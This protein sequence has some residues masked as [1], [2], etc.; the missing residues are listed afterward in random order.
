MKIKLHSY[1]IMVWKLK[2]TVEKREF[3]VSVHEFSEL[4]R[5]AY[6]GGGNDGWQWEQ[7]SDLQ[8]GVRAIH[9]G[10]E[11][12]NLQVLQLHPDLHCSHWTPHRSSLPNTR[13]CKQSDF[14]WKYFSEILYTCT[15]ISFW[16]SFL[17]YWH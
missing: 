9:G 13:P 2:N 6:R 17:H 3:E 14:S 12:H 1:P 5:K 4:D 11:E 7:K 16:Q 8:G 15:G 10:Q